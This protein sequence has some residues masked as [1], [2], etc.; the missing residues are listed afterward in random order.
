[1]KQTDRNLAGLSDKKNEGS[2]TPNFQHRIPYP[3]FDGY[4]SKDI[5]V[6]LYEWQ[7]VILSN[8]RELLNIAYEDLQGVEHARHST[9]V[10]AADASLADLQALGEYWWQTHKRRIS[11]ETVESEQ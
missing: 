9:L 5:G 11:P 6:V 8:A 7:V 10:L 3:D 4:E 2:I 1:M